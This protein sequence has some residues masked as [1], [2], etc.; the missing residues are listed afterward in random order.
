MAD[1]IE[2]EPRRQQPPA[3]VHPV[4]G[5]GDDRVDV[6]EV[7]GALRS[8]WLLGC[9]I[10]AA[11]AFLVLLVFSQITPAY[12]GRA[13]LVL[14]TQDRQ[15]VDVKGVL[16]GLSGEDD[17]I[18]TEVRILSSKNLATLVVDRLNLGVDDEFSADADR[19]IW[20]QTREALSSIF[21]RNPDFSDDPELMQRKNREAII[22]RVLKKLVVYRDGDSYALVVEFY[23]R[24]PRRAAKIANTFA[25]VYVENQTTTKRQASAQANSLLEDELK[26]LSSAVELSEAMV[27]QYRADAGLLDTDGSTLIEQQNAAL[28][29]EMALLSSEFEEREAKLA[30][31]K[32]LEEAG[33]SASELSVVLKSPVITALRTQQSEVERRYAE[34]TVR[35]GPDHPLRNSTRSELLR[36]RG[37]VKA[38]VERIAASI[39]LDAETSQR[40][41][42]LAEQRADTLRAQLTKTKQ[43]QV[44][45]RELERQAQT[46]RTLYETFL[47][48]YKEISA[49]E[50]L[51]Q[52]DA[53][54]ISNAE[55]PI[56]PSSPKLSMALLVTTVLSGSAGLGATFVAFFLSSGLRTPREVEAMTGYPCVATLPTVGKT[57][58]Q[59]NQTAN[60]RR[61]FYIENTKA[62]CSEILRRNPNQ[63]NRGVVVAITSALPGEAK[64]ATTA[65]IGRIAAARGI[66]TVCVDG[67]WKRRKLSSTLSRSTDNLKD[68]LVSR[69][70]DELI[71]TKTSTFQNLSILFPE[72]LVKEDA[73]LDVDRVDEIL[74][75]L[76][77]QYEL[78]LL[79]TPPL[80]AL[81]DSRWLAAAADICYVLARW[82][83]TPHRIVSEALQ[84]VHR[85]GANIA[86]VVLTRVSPSQSGIYAPY[87]DAKTS[88]YIQAYFDN[89]PLRKRVALSGPKDS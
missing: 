57:R 89:K 50:G 45:L 62:L 75:G 43:A 24:D 6:A 2:I 38:E 54:I 56:S 55:V 51:H 77:D 88:K 46:D 59:F 73:D 10:A 35:Y 17:A 3:H 78:I 44:R 39:R 72:D 4:A 18:Q 12:T 68:N 25:E 60:Y 11:T 67:D 8:Y 15:V 80:L 23:S 37:D 42:A 26:K 47:S 48:R 29:Q 9:S 84:I 36:I 64:T 52:E 66:K 40:R 65:S 27:E 86:G 49:Y 28:A 81:A 30:T 21:S 83:R 70:D 31:L 33:G 16:S 53:R 7:L 74:E 20:Q 82:Q 41:V 69:L 22:R 76:R 71:T 61:A 58:F 19:G 85:S 14:E 34:L 1:L 32:A 79:D 63:D 13:T 5:H 87:Y